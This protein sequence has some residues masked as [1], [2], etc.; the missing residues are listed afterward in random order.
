M[1]RDSCLALEAR[2]QNCWLCYPF[3]K[4]FSVDLLGAFHSN[5]KKKKGETMDFVPEV[6]AIDL[7]TIEVDRDTKDLLAALNA[8]IPNVVL[9]RSN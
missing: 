1:R 9:Q 5:F 8:N 2:E 3:R 7:E 6:S 4:E